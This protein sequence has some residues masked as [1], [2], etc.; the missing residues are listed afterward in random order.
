MSE[1]RM[2]QERGTRAFTLTPHALVSTARADLAK[3][4]RNK[5]DGGFI[6]T[7]RYAFLPEHVRNA[8]SPV[9]LLAKA[10]ADMERRPEFVK[11]RLA[12][13]GLQSSYLYD[14]ALIEQAIVIARNDHSPAA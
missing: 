2:L 13:R 6:G 14:A 7:E 9:G 10:I 1:Q 11:A 5:S 3:R 12:K 8:K 4:A